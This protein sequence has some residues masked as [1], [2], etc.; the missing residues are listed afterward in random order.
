MSCP[1][2]VSCT[3]VGDSTNA[4]TNL[5]LI[6]AW[7][8]NSWSV[9]TSPTP[10]CATGSVHVRDRVRVLHHSYSRT[11]FDFLTIYIG[12][13]LMIGLGYPL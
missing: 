4:T 5:A 9:V 13:L 8:G 7:N 10:A 1:T 2:T 12:P 6:E 3:A 11:G